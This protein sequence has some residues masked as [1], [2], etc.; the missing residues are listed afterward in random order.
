[1]NLS[2]LS[3]PKYKDVFFDLDGTLVDTMGLWGDAHVLYIR[4]MGKEPHANF[5]DE[6]EYAFAKYAK[7]KNSHSSVMEH[8]NNLYGIKGIT[9]EEAYKFLRE[10]VKSKLRTIEYKPYADKFLLELKERGAGLTLVT[11]AERDMIDILMNENENIKAAANFREVFDKRIITYNDVER[12]KPEPDCYLLA[13]SMAGSHKSQQLVFEESLHG[14]LAAKRAKLDT[15]IIYCKHADRDRAE[16]L[17]ITPYHAKCYSE[18]L[19]V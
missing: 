13:S 16:L 1:M 10:N 17:K 9:G 19:N 14:A 6:R 3:L 11:M 18:F 15:C 12:K 5:R 8:I 7:L 4:Q 2:T